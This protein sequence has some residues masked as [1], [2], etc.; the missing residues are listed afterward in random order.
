[1]NKLEKMNKDQLLEKV[2]LLKSEISDM[3]KNKEINQ[4]IADNTSDNIAITSFDLKA[5]YLY[6][7]P[8]VKQSLG[9]EP[10]EM[11]GKSFFDFIHPDDKKVLLPILKKYISQIVKKVFRIDDPNLTETLE[12]RFRNKAG[13]WR[14]IQSTIN[15]VGKNI[16]AVARDITDSKELEDEIRFS[17]ANLKMVLNAMDDMVFV[18]D[19]Y[20]CI[21]SF[22]ASDKQLYLKPKDF[23]GKTH[24]DVMPA[25]V[26][27]LFKV[28][29]QDVKMGKTATYQYQLKMLEGILWYAVNLSPIM[30]DGVYDGLVAVVRDITKLKQS[31]EKYIELFENINSGVAVYEVKNNGKDFIFSSF[32]KA[33]E[34]IE[35][36]NRDKLI[37]KSVLDV[38]PGIIN[39]GL[40][41][42]FQRVWKTGNPENY[43][44]SFYEDGRISGWRDNYIYK[45]KTGEI[46]SVYEDVTNLKQAEQKLKENANLLAESEKIAHIG[47]WELNLKTNRLIWSDEVYRIFGLEPKEFDATYEAFLSHVHPDDRTKADQAYTSSL[48]Q[49]DD[50]Y[51][52]EHRVIR[53]HSYE[54]RYVKEKCLHYKNKE[55][56]I[57]RS[58]GMIEDITERKNAEKALHDSELKFR[59]LAD[60][61]Y[62]WEYWIDPK[63]NYI[64]L[65]PSCERITGYSAEEFT[66]NPD[67]LVKIV[68]SDFKEIVQ[69]HYLEENNKDE[70][71][72][73][74]EFPIITKKGEEKWIEHNCRPVF[75]DKGEFVGRRGNNRDITENK[76]IV[77][78]LKE[79]EY[80]LRTLFNSM[81]DIVFEMDYDGRYVFIAPTSPE[82]MFKTTEETVGKTLHDIFP[83]EEAD[84]FLNFIRQ[85]IDDNKTK[86]IEYPLFL[87]DQTYWFEGT[88]TPKTKNTVLYIA[89]DI[90]SRK[91]AE[92]ES[93][94]AKEKLEV[95]EKK[96]RE[97]FEKS[98]DAI[99]ILENGVFVDCN[100]ATVEMFK[101]NKKEDILKIHPSDLSPEIQTDGKNSFDKAN[102]M[103]ESTIKN[104][105]HRFEWDYKK[106]DGKVFPAEVL[107]TAISN[108]PEKIIIHAVVRDISKNKNAQQALI[109][110]KENVEASEKKFRELYEKSGDAIL[111]IE[112]RK[113]IDCNNAA[114]D[115]LN[116]NNKTE[117]LN[118]HP[119]KLSPAKQPDGRKSKEKADEM[120]AIAIKNGTN[121]FEW[122]HLKSNG[123]V[124]PVEVLLTAISNEPDNE[125]IHVVLRDI[126]E[127]KKAENEIRSGKDYLEQLTNSM[128][129]T[130][131][132]VKMP[133]R[134]IEWAND[135]YKLLGYEPDEFVGHDTAFLYANKTEFQKFGEKIKIAIDDE[136][137]V[138]HA[139]QLLK[140]KNGEVFLAEIT[141]TFHKE[142]NEVVRITSIVRDITERIQM[143]E[144]I[145]SAKELAEEGERKFKA[146]T[147]QAME[148]ITVADMEGNY[149]FINP[150]FCNMSG[151]TEK[152]LLKLTVFDMKAKDQPQSSFYDSKG[153]LEGVPIRVNLQRKDGTE[154][155]TEI[156]GK[157]I[158]IDNQKFVLGT[159]RDITESVEAE[160]A[161]K[162]SEHLL[163][164]SQKVARIGS[165][166]LDISKGAWESSVVLDD[167]FGIDKDF[168][169]DFEGWVKIV[170]PE[171]QSM[172][173]DYFATNIL[174][175][176]ERFNKEYRIKK[177]ND[178]K[179]LWVHGLGKLEF[180]GD[181]NPIKMIGTIQDITERKQ[182]EENLNDI[183]EKLAAQNE[184]Y[185]ALNEELTETVEHVQS[186]NTE[187]AKA[188]DR[189]EESDRLKSAFLANMSHEIRTPMNGILGFASLL[190]IPNLTGD[191]LKKYV[192]II[193]K[194]GERML[195]IINDL[196]NISKIEAGQMEVSISPCN[197]NDQMEYLYTFFKPEAEREGLD[198]S[199]RNT[200]TSTEA[201]INTDGEKFY[202]ILTNL[203]KNAIKY[204]NEG[205]INFGYTK[206]GKNLEFFVK[207]TGIGIAKDRQEAIFERFVQADIEDTRVF[208]GAGLGL[209]ITKAYVKMLDGELWLESELGQG[210]QFYFTI[211]YNPEKKVKPS[212]QF[213]IDK[214]T[215][216][217]LKKLKVL[218]AEDEEFSDTYLTIVLKNICSEILHAKTGRK[219]VELCKENTDLDLILMDIKMPDMDGYE[220]TKE[221]RKFNKD[222]VIIA[223]TAYALEGDFEKA[224]LVGCNDY[225]SKPI[226]QNELLEKIRK[227]I[228]K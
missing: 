3:K 146:F 31:E 115:L 9:Y 162:N 34:K 138:L 105:T 132:S 190:K 157:N 134:V 177:I 197:I 118:V 37:G 56:T 147:N 91:L 8:S 192:S 169:K 130:V 212:S 21:R 218:I 111:I 156:V 206:K 122:D 72:F 36:I 161:L 76:I 199:F 18:L 112:N 227:H 160:N 52:I 203:I 183:N 166:I 196:I 221:I 123:D 78:A 104:G 84:I 151:Y 32:N 93:V 110:A 202:A 142:N 119:S 67:L 149:V 63:G 40:F 58:I 113:F 30:K 167:L 26:N 205:S 87:N 95:S 100:H 24:S 90:T 219:S 22:Y 128:W 69:Q 39:F 127:R 145:I 99:F 89:R 108:E 13:D 75:D 155:L 85:S 195:N 102:E 185:Q 133:E 70:Q 106:S 17:E 186:I 71:V 10:E 65:S 135:S 103:M 121:R 214:K 172:M 54:I 131:F 207:D 11:V 137:D 217:S 216:V 198:L 129:D 20:N 6:V 173:Q 179:V 80:N 44:V 175:N 35:N 224:L 19:E 223:Q 220:A 188:K 164:E 7:S 154:Y 181:G 109:I 201:V 204:S 60:Y 43:P 25:H 178:K 59:Q 191:Q 57:V 96:F 81:N 66:I 62:D 140:R 50:G 101:Y 189:A 86:N 42:V 187:L 116:Y 163:S 226:D 208:E 61:T 143:E 98:G 29:Q 222:I 51:E 5:K 171:D 126:T 28:A 180:D 83:K 27:E 92:Q 148:G 200:L 152:E 144:A 213:N 48:K 47:S 174:K 176:H 45:L 153:E 211:P 82:L 117:F 74:F 68:R 114:V 38:F 41:E 193:E 33:G 159:V 64:Y 194:S 94:V 150:A 97:L 210:S 139:T 125:V 209:S 53:D 77:E 14:F 4:I 23:I 182:A 120:M 170:S 124:I 79:S 73:S 158:E 107:L 55:G 2:N 136:K 225:I 184:E 1:M 88:A 215:F 165:Y 49:G 12:F 141:L 15:F 228:E 46:V 16:L 168:N